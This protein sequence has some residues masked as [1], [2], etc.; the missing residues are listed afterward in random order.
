MPASDHN[1][2]EH[3]LGG[4]MPRAAEAVGLI[5]QDDADANAAVCRDDFENDIEDAKCDGVG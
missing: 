1:S 4:D 5:W 3:Q 2:T